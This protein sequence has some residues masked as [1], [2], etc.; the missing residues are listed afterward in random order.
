MRLLVGLGNPGPEYA[1]TR[2]NAGFWCVDQVAAEQ[3]ASWRAFKGGSLAEYGSGD[4]KALL[5]KPLTFMNRSGEPVRQL[6]DYFGVVA[7]DI[8]VAADDVYVAPGSVRVRQGGGDG[9]HNGLKSLLGQLPDPG[10]LRARIGVGLYEQDP[11]RRQHQPTLDAY[12]LEP[13]PAH[14]HKLALGAIDRLAP[15]LVEWLRTGELDTF[16]LHT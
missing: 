13:M 2:H 9:G 8:C 3:G 11:E 10:F 16:T 1:K 6:A 15:L 5:F 12:V 14:E 4:T 7:A